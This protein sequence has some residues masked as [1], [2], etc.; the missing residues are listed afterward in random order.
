MMADS[1][2]IN[3]AYHADDP[4]VGLELSVDRDSFKIYLSDT[5]LFVTL[6]FWDKD[7]TENVIYNKLLNDKLDANLGYV[8]ENVVAQMIASNGSK[9]F[10]YTW[11]DD[12]NHR[13]EIDFLLSRGPK[14]CPVE[15]KSSG[16]SN[17]PSLDNFCTKFSERISN[18]YL[19]Y[20]KDLRKDQ[21]TLLVPI[22]MVGLL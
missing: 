13:F 18:R 9:L 3:V 17:H 15:V 16:Y 19:V 6:A 8:Y 4:R 20:T 1:R 7:F 21:E 22:Y 2:T 12:Q 14:L 11:L 10:Y 5:G